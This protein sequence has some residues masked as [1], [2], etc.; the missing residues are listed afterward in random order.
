MNEYYNEYAD[1]KQISDSV[2]AYRTN[3][4]KNNIH[5][6]KQAFDFM[7]QGDCNVIVGDFKGFFDNLDHQYLKRMLCKVLGTEMLSPDWYAVYKNITRYSTWDLIDILK[8]NNLI[9]DEDIEKK[10]SAHLEALSG[11]T[12]KAREIIKYFD[13]KIEI[14]N[15]FNISDV[16]LRSKKLALSKEQFKQQKKNCLKRHSDNFGIPQG[17]SISAVLSNAYMIEFDEKINNLMKK[18]DGLYLRYS[19]DF[20]II[21]PKNSILTFNEV[22]TYLRGVV[23]E[24]DKLTLESKKTQIYN[25]ENNEITNIT[26]SEN[27]HKS[28]IDYLGFVFDG[29]QVTLRPK[30]V[31]KYYYRMY[32]KLNTIVRSGGITKN[33]NKISYSELYS[34]YTQKGRS[35]QYDP[36]QLPRKVILKNKNN[37]YKSGN[38][39]SYVHKAD[40]IFNP[41][42]VG[43]NKVDSPTNPKEPITQATKRHML[44]IRRIRQE[45]KGNNGSQ[46]T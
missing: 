5:F 23:F 20:I 17:S 15:G 7:R 22:V 19:D 6:A 8:L 26:D 12:R 39:F 43:R 13:E 27:E 4:H 28:Y 45:I 10:E 36:S 9:T 25:Y 34:T 29:K 38:F 44:K 41:E 46:E 14:L 35:G 3:L 16:K 24:T 30:T 32:K 37:P 42:Y 33:G 2:V 11:R 18:M 40:E 1:T 31:S 21:L